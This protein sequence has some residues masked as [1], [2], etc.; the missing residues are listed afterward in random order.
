M[1][2]RPPVADLPAFERPPVTEALLSI[3]FAPLTALQSA[4]M[5]LLWNDIRGE[6]PRIS[7]QPPLSSVFETFGGPPPQA[8]QFRIETFLSPPMPRFWFEAVEGEHLLQVQQ[9]RI[10]HNWRKRDESQNYPRYDE[11]RRRLETEIGWVSSFLQRE[12]LGIFVP[13]QCEVTYTNVISTP[14]DINPHQHLE[15]VTT[16]WTAWHGGPGLGQLENATV[17]ARFVLRAGDE[18]V[19]RIYANLAPTFLLSDLRPVLHL[20]ITARGRPVAGTIAAAFEFLD[21]AHE[22]AVRTFDAVTTPMMH[23][24]WGKVNV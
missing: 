3:Q 4:H 10:I 23:K 1:T 18:L 22:A 9:D 7:E 8:Q 12:Q 19:G 16:L 15:Q 24:I 11:V 21:M 6:Y 17:Q 14:D 2:T 13:N 5:G 20:E